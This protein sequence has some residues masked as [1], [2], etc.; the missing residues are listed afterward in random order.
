MIGFFLLEMNKHF[1]IHVLI[2]SSLKLWDLDTY[3]INSLQFDFIFM[4]FTF[5]LLKSLEHNTQHL[6]QTS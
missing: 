4:Q 5:L 1:I 2:F 6:L 3:I